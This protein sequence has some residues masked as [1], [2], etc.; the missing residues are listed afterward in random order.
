MT[1]RRDER[2]MQTRDE[3]SDRSTIPH[4]LRER[5][6][7]VLLVWMVFSFVVGALTKFYWGETWFGPS[8]SVKF[9]EWGY[10]S[11]FRI[12]VGAGELV[13][14]VMLV[15]PR[16]RFLGACILVVITSGAVVTHLANQDPIGESI[17]APIHLVLSLIVA[18]AARPTRAPR[19]S[20]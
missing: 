7:Q 9:A 1:N 11:W 13:G 20:R 19:A 4:R 18:W 12:V 8:Y 16:L 5:L 2:D 14:A 3:L 17:S 10:P 15:S 6:F